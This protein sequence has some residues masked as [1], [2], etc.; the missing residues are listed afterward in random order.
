M[1]LSFTTFSQEFL[2][3]LTL[4]IKANSE[5][6]GW[7]LTDVDDAVVGDLPAAL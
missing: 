2:S 5:N 7:R 1:S 4:I 3:F 6:E